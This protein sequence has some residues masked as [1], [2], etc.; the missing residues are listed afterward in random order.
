MNTACFLLFSLLQTLDYMGVWLQGEF[1]Q[2][3]VSITIDDCMVLEPVLLKTKR[4]TGLAG[5]LII[6]QGVLVTLTKGLDFPK[7]TCWI[8]QNVA[9]KVLLKVDDKE[10][11][12]YFFPKQGIHL[13]VVFSDGEVYFE[14]RFQSFEPTCIQGF[15]GE[16]TLLPG[17]VDASGKLIEVLHYTTKK[18]LH[19]KEK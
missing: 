18:L 4:S 8:K 5:V 11:F 13:R 16:D 2:N 6:E 15:S 3:L 14:Q 19:E 10:W 12:Y 9:H 7:E 1:K 17:E